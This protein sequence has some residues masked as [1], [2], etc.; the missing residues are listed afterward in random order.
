MVRRVF[1]S[2]HYE[3]DIWRANIVRKS[4]VTKRTGK[5]VDFI[6]AAEFE[7]IKRE[8]DSAIKRWI[9]D[10]LKGTSVTAVLIGA[11]TY[12]RKWVRYEIIRSFDKGNG[13]F[14]IYIHNIKDK[15][16]NID[17][18]GKNPFEYVGVYISRD[19]K[20][21]YR[22]YKNDKWVIFEDSKCSLNFDEKYWND[23]V[24]TFKPKLYDWVNDGGY[25]SIG[26]WI[27]EAAKQAGR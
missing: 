3:R 18:N 27:E 9:N 25:D 21:E 23:K 8:G 22:E 15:N 26:E 17:N 24:Y 20:A 16:G 5:A 14:G 10:Q 11:E 2:F 6:D 7:K 19:G 4:W 13:L 12:K 1:F